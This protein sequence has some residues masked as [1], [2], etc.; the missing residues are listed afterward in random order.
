MRI[1]WQGTCKFCKGHDFF[2][3][4]VEDR[5]WVMCCDYCGEEHSRRRPPK[6]NRLLALIDKAVGAIK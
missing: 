5:D 2:Y 3:L 4:K 1:A 6:K